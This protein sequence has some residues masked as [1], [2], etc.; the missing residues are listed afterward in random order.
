MTK[1]LLIIFILIISVPYLNAQNRDVQSVVGPSPNMTSLF[2]FND[3]PISLFTGTNQVDVPIYTIKQGSIELP[4]ALMY[5]SGGIK[6]SESASWAG[7][8]WALN[9][10]GAIS[11]GIYGKP[12]VVGGPNLPKYN[13]P[14]VL[15]KCVVTAILDGTLDSQPDIF[16]FN[17]AGI[18]GSFYL[19]DSNVIQQIPYSKIRIEPVFNIPGIGLAWRLTNTDGIS[20]L[21][22]KQET[23]VSTNQNVNNSSGN[24]SGGN[25]VPGPWNPYSVSSNT[26]HLTQVASPD[27]DTVS[28]AYESYYCEA[29]NFVGQTNF[30]TGVGNKYTKP[31]DLTNYELQ[32]INGWR[33]KKISMKNGSINFI[34]GGNRCDALEDKYLS[35]INVT[36][37]NNRVIKKYLLNY[38]YLVAG[39]WSDLS[40]IDC[41]TEGRPSV[42]NVD[43]TRGCLSR[44]LM[45]T[46]VNEV[47][48]LTNSVIGSYKMEY[49]N[50]FG[51][52]SRFSSQ[53]DYW[54]YYNGN[55]QSSLLQTLQA[56]TTSYQGIN[57]PF[58]KGRD[59]NL[60][61][62][63]QGSLTKITYPTGGSSAFTY[64]LNSVRQ[65]STNG[66]GG[67]IA[68][69]T[70]NFT[71]AANVGGQTIGSFV[72]NDCAGGAN[73]T[74]QVNGCFFTDNMSPSTVLPFG[75]TVQK[76]GT[77]FVS[78]Q[79]I[80][81]QSNGHAVTGTSFYLSNGTYFI[82]S[83][84]TSG[85][86]CTY[87]LT[88]PGRNE[89]QF[90]PGG[91]QHEKVVGGIRI[92][93]IDHLDPL[94][95]R[96]L[97]KK[98]D[99]TK[100]VDGITA[101]SGSTSDP[102]EAPFNNVNV[103]AMDEAT[104]SDNVF[105]V[106]GPVYPLLALTSN[107]NYPLRMTHGAQV[108][109]TRVTERT[110]DENGKDAG[111][112]AYTYS[113]PGDE[114]FQSPIVLPSNL[115]GSVSVDDG[116]LY[117]FAPSYSED[118]QRGLLLAKELYENDG[119]GNYTLVKKEEN[120]YSLAK[121]VDTAYGAVAAYYLDSKVPY[122]SDCTPAFGPGYKS[123]S[124]FKY[125]P[126]RIYS[127][128][129]T[130]EK[131]ITNQIDINGNSISD[132]TLYGYTDG[133]LQPGTIKKVNSR[134]EIVTVTN[135]Y[136]YNYT[137]SGTP[138]NPIA[139]GVKKLQGLNI[140]APVIESY[141]QVSDS[142]GNNIRTV[143]GVFTTY[144]PGI[145]HPDVVYRLE[146]P[147]VLSGFVSANINSGS[148][149]FDNRYKPFI[150]YD[151]YDLFGNLLQQ[152][153]A[154]DQTHA[155][156]WDYNG[157]YP[158]AEVTGG[159]SN[160][161]CYTSFETAATGNWVLNGG[162]VTTTGGLTGNK[163]YTISSGN[164]ITKGSLPS[165]D[166]IVSYWT[167]GAALTI[168]GVSVTSTLSR[169]GWNYY[170]QKL[171]G[172]TAIS[173]SGI[174]TLDELR[175]YPVGAEMKTYTYAP[176]VG[177]TSQTSPD[178]KTIYYEYD[179]AS[180]L[181]LIRD[182]DGKVL[183]QYDYQYQKPVTQ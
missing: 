176:L 158:I 120:I 139:T 2:K 107:T 162:T 22:E 130:L 118:W 160:N 64:E 61:Y 16:Q 74:F 148:A 113:D 127:K 117:P 23:V 63:T 108:G 135:R 17:F 26:W 170:E 90:I 67:T 138:S 82:Y 55:G 71:L 126:Y 58:I 96:T 151:T 65:E 93:Q 123:Y 168:N 4:V 28:I 106:Q 77:T 167:K 57:V 24:N 14:A 142:N 30:Y 128:Y 166:Y 169:N 171:L 121:V 125:T 73:I 69:P 48:P 37:V 178:N 149:T 39:Q 59:P 8:G 54:G 36:D 19:N 137:I 33:I 95:N 103:T 29:Q 119:S 32:R 156:I 83:Y 92:K 85:P 155:Y 66:C 114:S 177:M 91:N 45:L 153:K 88:I 49:E 60:Q 175:L 75:F 18:S 79:D 94:G 101:S 111:V 145:S 86:A 141:T 53:Q 165:G 89:P 105:Y 47:D 34:T 41:S 35:E 12:D 147:G 109:Y 110:I 154:D 124:I 70:K 172:I 7:L 72:V 129:T 44:R 11:Q 78:S 25:T 52:P 10:G 68:V 134:K 38:R 31:P 1:K 181:K 131:T 183:K 161:I 159:L 51:L 27:G 116:G 15:N 136:P 157:T 21:F 152:H 132:T 40:Q 104:T 133:Y 122:R 99:Y 20:Y 140:I 180:R 98:Y 43:V 50:N 179:N 6:V 3:Q 76:S 163:G 102:L 56:S 112:T 173:V 81:S 80:I 115:N 164:T 146:T 143:S 42:F 97:M 46:G 150:V 84:S 100:T 174:G 13:K 144:K 87:S 62:A 5:H 9:A 182:Q